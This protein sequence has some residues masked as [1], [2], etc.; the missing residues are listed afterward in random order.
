MWNIL[1]LGFHSTPILIPTICFFVLGA[2]TTFDT[3]LNRAIR[4]GEVPNDEPPL[5]AWVATLYWIYY[6][7]LVALLILNWKF[8][9]LVFGIKLVLGYFDILTLVGNVM[10]APFKPRPSR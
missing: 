7:I 10:M 9:L 8:G 5:P 4:R 1:T 3:D 2:I 6:G